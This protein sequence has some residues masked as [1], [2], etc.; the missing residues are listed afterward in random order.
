[1]SILN[2]VHSLLGRFSPATQI[3]F[4]QENLLVYE[5]H[6]RLNKNT[7]LV[8]KKNQT[9]VVLYNG[10]RTTPLEQGRHSLDMYAFPNAEATDILCLNTKTLVSRTWQSQYQPA[11]RPLSS[12]ITGNYKVSIANPEQFT[13][14]I[15]SH[16]L[17]N[18]DDAFIDQWVA[19]HTDSILKNE[20]IS[21]DDIE[22]QTT[23]LQAFLLAALKHTITRQGLIL[24]DFSILSPGE[25]AVKNPTAPIAE[26]LPKQIQEYPT[27]TVPAAVDDAVAAGQELPK[28][29]QEKQFYRV[30]NGEQIG[31][32]SI[33]EIQQL[34]NE[35]SISP[36]DLLWQKGMTS[37]Q[38]AKSFP[39]FSWR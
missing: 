20:Q 18:P 32:L 24:H 7:I 13:D 12:T 16:A 38:P 11:E 34:I 2:K 37:W 36:D 6:H 35:Q 21:A 31:P 27:E 3:Q 10:I 23:K 1:M 22:Y 4:G 17:P 39:L 33:S 25:P 28:Q 26:I 14:N 8:L 19:Y 5:K 9:A 30:D 15:I 29:A